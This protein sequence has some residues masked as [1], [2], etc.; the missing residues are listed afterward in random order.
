MQKGRGEALQE[1]LVTLTVK[2]TFWEWQ[3]PAKIIKAFGSL[4]SNVN[5][6]N[7]GKN[8]ATFW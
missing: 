2:E 6:I 3:A 5:L 7:G 1:R 4:S 8:L